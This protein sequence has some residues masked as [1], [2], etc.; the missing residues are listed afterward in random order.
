MQR[1]GAARRDRLCARL[2]LALGLLSP[3]LSEVEFFLPLLEPSIPHEGSFEFFCGIPIRSDTHFCASIA[4]CSSD[5]LVSSWWVGMA[6]PLS[7]FWISSLFCRTWRMWRAFS[8]SSML[9][10]WYKRSWCWTIRD[11]LRGRHPRRFSSP[12]MYDE[13]VSP[14]G[15]GYSGSSDRGR[16]GEC[17]IPV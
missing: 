7:N 12:R 16:K 3:L 6:T 13:D 9:A 11:S 15:F 8:V 4:L 10:S 5:N 1:G 2:L 14:M 17:K